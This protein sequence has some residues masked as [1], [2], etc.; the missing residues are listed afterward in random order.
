MAFSVVR[1]RVSWCHFFDG[2]NVGF[3]RLRLVPEVILVQV[4]QAERMLIG[5]LPS[6]F[7]IGQS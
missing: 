3:L 4:S 7:V 5:N 1:A 2:R 6:F